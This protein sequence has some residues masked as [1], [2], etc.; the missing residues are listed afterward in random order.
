MKIVEKPWGREVWIAYENGRY[1]GKIL[2]IK[3]G[4][5][6]SLQ[7]HEKKHETLYLLQGKVRFT[8]EDEN[9]KLLTEVI[10]HGGVKIVK[11]G[12]R[13]RMEAIRDSALVE[14]SSPELE[15]V[16]RMEDDYNR[17]EEN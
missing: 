10:Q 14:F 2:E 12:K 4:H 16:V 5:R 13:H 6:L 15:D 8:L 3:E 9:G 17:T 7:Y 11:P 1:A